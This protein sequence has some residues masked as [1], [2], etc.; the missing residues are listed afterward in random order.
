MYDATLEDFPILDNANNSVDIAAFDPGIWSAFQYAN[1]TVVDIVAPQVDWGL[2]ADPVGTVFALQRTMITNVGGSPLIVSGFCAPNGSTVSVNTVW[3][4]NV[5]HGSS[6][7]GCRTCV[8]RCM[9]ESTVPGSFWQAWTW[10]DCSLV[11]SIAK[12]DSIYYAVSYGGICTV[13]NVDFDVP[14]RGATLAF[15]SNSACVGIN[16]TG[17]PGIIGMSFYNAKATGGFSADVREGPMLLSQGSSISVLALTVEN[18]GGV[19]ALIVGGAG[20]GD[21]SAFNAATILDGTRC[22]GSTGNTTFGASIGLQSNLA[23]PNG[24]PTLT[25]TTNDLKV[26]AA[27]ARAWGAGAESDPV[28]FARFDG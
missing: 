16:A 13:Y 15:L 1:G 3:L 7:Y 28:L 4:A 17:T 14:S 27:A 24:A 9:S 6:L 21:G 23:T 10:G 8:S 20:A 22:S 19:P 12:A 18:A 26:G 2:D 5:G 25:G 11:G